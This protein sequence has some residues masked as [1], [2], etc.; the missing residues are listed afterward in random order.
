MK[1]I[2]KYILAIMLGLGCRGTDFSR[3]KVFSDESEFPC[4][5]RCGLA[6]SCIFTRLF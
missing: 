5:F 4:K 1:S 2:K 3:A 6:N